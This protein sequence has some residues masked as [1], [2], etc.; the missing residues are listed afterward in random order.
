MARRCGLGGIASPP[1]SHELPSEYLEHVA[2]PETPPPIYSAGSYATQRPKAK[3]WLWVAV[4]LVVI[5]TTI[6]GGVIGGLHQRE[7]AAN[8]YAFS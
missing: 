5:I 3:K 8:T 2:R 4:V 1:Y 7:N 6:T